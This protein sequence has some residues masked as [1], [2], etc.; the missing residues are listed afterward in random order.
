[1]IS[2]A[3]TGTMFLTGMDLNNEDPLYPPGNNALEVYLKNSFDM[4]LTHSTP[5]NRHH[6]HFMSPC[7]ADAL[8]SNSVGAIAMI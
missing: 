6:Y 4:C 7:L 2:V 5:I 1:M 8:L 3:V